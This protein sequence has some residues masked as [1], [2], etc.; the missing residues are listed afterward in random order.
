[1]LH[2][3]FAYNVPCLTKIDGAKVRH[4]D[5]VNFDCGAEYFFYKGFNLMFEFNWLAGGD[6]KMDG[7]LMPATDITQ[8]QISPGIGWSNDR[9][10][11]LLAYQRTI[12]GTNVD[13]NDSIIFTF[14]RVF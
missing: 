11:T 5:Y 12:A 1:M 2:A 4:G 8:V 14:V 10:Q 6:K 13:V 3:D 7:L 9:I